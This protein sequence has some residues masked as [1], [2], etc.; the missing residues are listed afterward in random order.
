MKTV[1]LM[2]P[3]CMR[4]RGNASVDAEALRGPRVAVLSPLCRLSVADPGLLDAVRDRCTRAT[5]PR[6]FKCLDV[7]VEK[8][9]DHALVLHAAFGRLGLEEEDAPR[10]Q[11]DGDLDRVFLENELL[12]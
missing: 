6:G 1:R 3:W 10:A 8:A 4:W 5:L 11:G 9:P 12:R 7:R 2:H